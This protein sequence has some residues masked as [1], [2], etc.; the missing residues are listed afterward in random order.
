MEAVNMA[1]QKKDVPFHIAHNYK[2]F[3][4]GVDV[5]PTQDNM[6][7]WARDEEDA[8]LY[9]LRIGQLHPRY[10]GLFLD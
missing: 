5:Y 7:F 2:K 4:L 6:S 8:K 10:K 1:K 9:V 3:T